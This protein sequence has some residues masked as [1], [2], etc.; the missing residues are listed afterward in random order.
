MS[1]IIEEMESYLGC[2]EDEY[3]AHYG[4]PRR[5]GRYPWGSGKEPFQSSLDFLGR[6]EEM[7]KKGFK[8]TDEDGKTWTGDNAIAKSLGYNSTDF[9]TVYAIAK[10][11]RRSYDVARAQSL[12][13]DGLNTSQIGRKIT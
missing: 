6:V 2:G 8:Y 1:S 4:M 9:R 12:K 10:D 3:L 13:K 7:R 5:S 11:E